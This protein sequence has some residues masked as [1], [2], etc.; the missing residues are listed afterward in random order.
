MGERRGK[1]GLE[2]SK[3]VRGGRRKGTGEGRAREKEGHER[4]ELQYARAKNP[5]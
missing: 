1:T 3:E 2:K 5:K 4:N